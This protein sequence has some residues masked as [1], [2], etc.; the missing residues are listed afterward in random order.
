MRASWPS[1][2]ASLTV[3]YW[4]VTGCVRKR[5][6]YRQCPTRRQL[7]VLRTYIRVGSVAAA[8]YELG[9]GA[10]TVRQHLSGLH[11]RTGCLNVAQAAYVPGLSE[12]TRPLALPRPNASAATA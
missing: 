2:S 4:T 1:T 5:S 10:T 9:I 12:R 3:R 8:A 11:R 7:E 6:T